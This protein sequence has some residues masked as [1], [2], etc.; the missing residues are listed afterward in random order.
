MQNVFAP[1]PVTREM[2]R[3]FSCSETTL[4]ILNAAA[5]L[6]WKELEEAADPL[7]AGLV[8][9]MDGACGLLWGASLAAGVRARALIPDPAGVREATL[10]ASIGL[11]EAYRRAGHPFDCAQITGLNTWNFARYMLKG[12]I[13]VCSRLISGMAPEF[14]A[15]IDR[16]IDVHRAR[17][18]AGRCRNCAVEAYDRVC[19][20][21]DLAADGTGAVAAGFAG[22][23][24]LSG[25]AC[26]ALAAAI[27]AVS[28]KYFTERNRPKH[29][30]IRS[31]L[32]GLFL[33]VG[34]MRPSMEI[35]RRFRA[36]FPGKT[37]RSI[38]GRA[39]ASADELAAHLD[40]G[41]CERVLEAVAAAAREAVRTASRTTS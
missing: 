20:A 9:E 21:I 33:G 12:N 6:G 36:G 41:R 1:A 23:L 22:G 26:G 31:D 17:G 8:A 16:T 10:A 37:C 29:S 38:A 18:P 13:R 39:F 28:M 27:L 11:V 34:W 32:Q 24:G 40:S 19:R 35:A 14:H 30:M 3:R 4:T 25:N 7:C 2:L 5:S 15:I